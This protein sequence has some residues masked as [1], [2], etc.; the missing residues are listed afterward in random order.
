M[1]FHGYRNRQGADRAEVPVGPLV[2]LAVQLLVLQ[3]CGTLLAGHLVLLAMYLLA[4]H[5]AVLDESAGIAVLELDGV[6]SVLAAVGTGF[7][8][9]EDDGHVVVHCR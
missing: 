1:F 6:A 7:S 5:A 2:S 3:F 8:A 9:I 4:V